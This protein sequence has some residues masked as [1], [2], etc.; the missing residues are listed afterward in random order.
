MRREHEFHELTYVTNEE[1]IIYKDLSF[2]E[3]VFEVQNILGAG[4]SENLY[5]EAL[6]KEFR[7]RGIEHERQKLIE[8]YYKGEKIGEYRLDMIVEG[9]IILELKAVSEL[10]EIFQSQLF[11][12]LKATG[13]KL[14]ILINFGSKRI[15]YKRIV[16]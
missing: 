16:K 9:K 1:K 14:G 2:M 4:Y 13:M 10:N 6:A 8:V 3:A 7:G 11:S 15:E 5:E 12:Y